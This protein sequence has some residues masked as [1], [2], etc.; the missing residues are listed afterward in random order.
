MKKIIFVVALVS[1]LTLCATVFA[2]CGDLGIG[3]GDLGEYWKFDYY[4]YYFSPAYEELK[5]ASD[6]FYVGNDPDTAQYYKNHIEFYAEQKRN[7]Q[8]AIETDGTVDVAEFSEESARVSEGVFPV[9]LCPN[10][11]YLVD[12]SSVY[13]TTDWWQSLSEDERRRKLEYGIFPA[14]DRTTCIY[15]YYGN[16]LILYRRFDRLDWS[17]YSQEDLISSDFEIE[18]V[19]E[20]PETYY[21]SITCFH[22]PLSYDKDAP[23]IAGT[24]WT[25]ESVSFVA[26][27]ET[28]SLCETSGLLNYLLDEYEG[29]MTLSVGEDLRLDYVAES[30]SA[31]VGNILLG[32]QDGDYD[33]SLIAGDRTD[34]DAISAEYLYEYAD[35][36]IF[37]RL[38]ENLS[39]MT[40]TQNGSKIDM[41]G[42]WYFGEEG[43][44]S[45]FA[46]TDGETLVINLY[47]RTPE[48]Y[49]R[50]SYIFSKTAG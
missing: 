5:L 31:E 29:E 40:L 15:Y 28:T 47:D 48:S 3:Q 32:Y 9:E 21:Y 6:G 19:P 11:A 36:L 49:I 23:S 26:D 39:A 22:K 12:A 17:V 4:S 41:Q 7:I 38:S 1:A 16:T 43:F 2:G 25:L 33:W 44:G 8:Q 42:E 50:F 18:Y 34:I 24:T 14:D 45:A 20:V 13:D 37:D 46:E 10:G 27:R 30:D 35:Q